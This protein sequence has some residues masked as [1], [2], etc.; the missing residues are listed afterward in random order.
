MRQTFRKRDRI[1]RDVDFAEIIRH[2][3]VAANGVL[4]AFVR[5]REAGAPVRMGVTI[6]KK[7]GNA[8]VRNRWKRWIRE[9]FRD[10][11]GDLEPGYDIVLR[12]KKGAQGS[13]S[14]IRRGMP[15]LIKRAIAK[16]V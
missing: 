5:R 14:A 12:P 11:R 10:C 6:P 9:A 1:V 8:V 15:K 4:V 16:T 2:G 7:T 3:G 13:W